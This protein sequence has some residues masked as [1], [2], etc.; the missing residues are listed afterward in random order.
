LSRPTSLSGPSGPIV[1]DRDENGVALI[2]AG[3]SID[4]IRGLGYCHARDRGLQMLFVRI[5]GRGQASRWL[6][7]TDKMLAIDKY[8]RRLDFLGDVET[9][10]A[11]LTTSAR[12]AVEAYSAG[13]NT[14]FEESGLPWELRLLGYHK[15]FEPWT[16]AD[17]VLT[18][19][20]IGYVSLGATQGEIE[21]WIVDCVR[22]GVPVPALEELFPGKLDGLDVDLLRRLTI[23]EPVVPEALWSVAGLPWAMASNSWVV[24]GSR[25]VSGKP[26]LCNDP[27][28]EI[29]RI[30]PVWYEAVLRWHD[31]AGASHYALGATMPG[32]PGVV[33]GRNADVAWGV[34][35]AYMDCVDSWIEDCR[36]GLYRRGED[37]IP[38]RVR[39]ETV[40]RKDL[41]SVTFRFHDTAEHG[42]ID[43]DPSVPSLHLA[44]RW[45]CGKNTAAATV[46]ALVGLL[47]ARTADEAR[48]ILGQFNNSCWNVVIADRAGSIGSQMTGMMP[49]RRDGASGLVPLPGWDPANDWQGFADPHDLP[50]TLDPPGGLI[51]A[52]N[53]DLN[54]LGI[55]KPINLSVNPYRA[56]RIAQVLESAKRK[57]DVD[58]MTR[59]QLD[60]KST[61]AERFLPIILPLLDEFRD[62]PNVEIL[63]RWD[64]DYGG[65]SLG[66]TVFE[67]FY[68]ALYDDV[69]GGRLG[70]SAL[71]HLRNETV[72]LVEYYYIFDR[73]LLSARSRWFAGRTRAQVYRSALKVAL[74]EDAVPHRAS[75]PLYFGHILLGGRLPRFLG[76][77]H[78][79]IEL[80]GCRATVSQCQ[81]APIAGRDSVGGPSIRFTTDM[82]T[83]EVH[84][85]LPGGP[86][87]RRFSPWY[88]SELDD[89]LAGKT[90]VV[91][92]DG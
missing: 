4:A 76:F 60:L 62:N 92:G 5:L 79:P 88:A 75:P 47:D 58:D 53:N 48:T 9:E 86:S 87:D 85:S 18:G 40:E 68:R 36:D 13:V 77:D 49:L 23:S 26:I 54:H 37:W 63:R 59:L 8:F 7:A 61:Q 74:A 70:A 78:G 50:R 12:A 44:T 82:A 81:L 73:I 39:E 31:S 72:L 67:R 16:F 84:T 65:E 11:A 24:D 83:A 41:A 33:L 15:A 51:V 43:G 17:S 21:R 42:T 52:A 14:Y 2:R 28:L 32:A 34:T 1:L 89:Y 46:G 29:N 69:F 35:Y 25:T 30:P 19:K 38:F 56:D 22:A 57:L 55:L 10:F 66:A 91:Q 71:A 3:S 80:R 27:H 20:V 45:S 90:K 64:F 6:E